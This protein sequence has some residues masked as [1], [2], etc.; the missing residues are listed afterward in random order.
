MEKAFLL[1]SVTHKTRR[2]ALF[3]LITQKSCS[4]LVAT[5]NL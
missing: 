3:T 4:I 5:W 2:V 1:L